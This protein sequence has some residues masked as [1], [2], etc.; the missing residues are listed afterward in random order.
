M[1]IYEFVCKECQ[2]RFEFLQMRSNEKVICPKCSSK[3]LKKV[4][5]APARTSRE[6]DNSSCPTGTCPTGT[7][8]FP[9]DIK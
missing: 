8:G 4:M 2:T 1:P 9:N 7:C 6:N 5:S 3:K